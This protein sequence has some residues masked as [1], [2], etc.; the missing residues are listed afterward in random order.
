MHIMF[1]ARY[2]CLLASSD[3]PCI[4]NRFL[5]PFGST[6]SPM[7]QQVMTSMTYAINDLI[8]FNN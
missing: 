1:V 4:S 3:K 6:E 7:I 8:V 2:M 5:V